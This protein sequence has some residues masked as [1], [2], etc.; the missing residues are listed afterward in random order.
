V[1]I[2]HGGI[3]MPQSN[4]GHQNDPTHGLNGGPLSGSLTGELPLGEILSCLPSYG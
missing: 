3:N 1:D 2:Y 4:V